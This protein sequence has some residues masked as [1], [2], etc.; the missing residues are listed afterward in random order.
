MLRSIA[1]VIVG[2]GWAG[3]I[4]ARA[5]EIGSGVLHPVVRRKSEP[6]H[7]EDSLFWGPNQMEETQTVRGAWRWMHLALNWFEMRCMNPFAFF[8]CDTERHVEVEQILWIKRICH[9]HNF[10]SRTEALASPQIA[11]LGTPGHIQNP[12][13]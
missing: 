11:K 7:I 9:S 13:S 4:W 5:S 10:L 1:Q 3:R 12:A 6:G 8:V 2:W